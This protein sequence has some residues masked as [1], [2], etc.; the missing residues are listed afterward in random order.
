MSADKNVSCNDILMNQEC[1]FTCAEGFYGQGKILCNENLAWVDHGECIQGCENAIDITFPNLESHDNCIKQREGSECDYRC[2]ENHVKKGELRCKSSQWVLEGEGCP[3]N[4]CELGPEIEN[5][6]P[7]SCLNTSLDEICPFTCL[8]N[9]VSV[10]TVRCLGKLRGWSTQGASCVKGC[11]RPPT[12]PAFAQNSDDCTNKKVGATCPFVC[13]PDSNRIAQGVIVCVERIG[14]VKWLTSAS[15]FL[16]CKDAPSIRS[17][18]EINLINPS[19]CNMVN[20]NAICKFGCPSGY[21]KRGQIVCVVNEW[22]FKDVSCIQDLCNMAIIPPIE[23]LDSTNMSNCKEG[24]N[25]ACKAGYH[26]KGRIFCDKANLTWK[27]DNA[28]CERFCPENPKVLPNSHVQIPSDCRNFLATKTCPFTCEEGFTPSGSIDCVGGSYHWNNLAVC[29]KNCF[30]APVVKNSDEEKL[31]NCREAQPGV[32]CK[33]HCK[34]GYFHYGENPE[35]LADGTWELS[36][37]Y[38]EVEASYENLFFKYF[39]I[40]LGSILAVT[41]FG[42][43]FWITFFPKEDDP[44]TVF[45]IKDVSFITFGDMDGDFE[46]QVEII[47]NYN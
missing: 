41:V 4:S 11:A 6:D 33:L 39:E 36:K 18:S 17:Y 22:V 14:G 13:Q 20:E 28:K 24:C 23:G 32:Q 7:S 5:V 47:D 2:S 21:V 40:F 9:Y 15:C 27:V 1:Q 10:G 38:C 29:T 30:L 12:L 44:N 19:S 34:K 25:T 43:M 37:S 3:L 46:S 16:G 45:D 42:S 26:P 35:C 8:D 31:E